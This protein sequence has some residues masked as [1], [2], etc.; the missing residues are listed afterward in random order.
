MER[1]E[2]P[3]PLNESATLLSLRLHFAF[4]IPSPL[5]APKIDRYRKAMVWKPH[6]RKRTAVINW[7]TECGFKIIGLKFNGN[8]YVID[9]EHDADELY[10]W[11]DPEDSL[12]CQARETREVFQSDL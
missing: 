10:N 12:L 4:L 6:S 5:L 7:E 9:T 8:D 3:A 1:G 11:D 2:R